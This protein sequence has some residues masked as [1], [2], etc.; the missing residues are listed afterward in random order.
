MN[1][2]SLSARDRAAVW[3]PFTPQ[4]PVQDAVAL[5][6]GEGALLFGEDGR[7]Y[8]DAT[9]SWWVNLHGHAHPYIAQKIAVQLVTLEHA[10]FSGF[11]HEPAVELA[12]RL[13]GRLPHMSKVFYSDDGS[14]A[15][16]VALKMALQY[17]HNKGTPRTKIVAFENAY[18]GDT[19]GAMSA[20]ARNVFSRAFGPLLFEVVH[21][22]VPLPGSEDASLNALTEA[23]DEHTAAFIAEPLIQGAGG[24]IMYEAE[25]LSRIYQRCK[26][27]GIPVIAD[28]VMTG[29]GRTGTWFA[30]DQCTVKP[31]MICLSKGL[32]GGFMPLGVTLCT[33]EI[34]AAFLTSDRTRTFFH[35]HSYTANATACAA[36]LASFDLM[37]EAHTQQQIHTLAHFQ[38]AQTRRLKNH[39]AVMQARCKGTIAA[40]ELRSTESTSYLNP[41]S[42]RVHPFFLERGVILRPLGNIIYVL[43]PYCITTKQ[44]E[45]VYAA[46]EEFLETC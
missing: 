26:D 23:L 31:D 43:P 5:V 11:T 27:K 42:E 9:A 33:E 13:L 18:H 22:P 25:A 40:F 37:E 38:Q 14:T 28:E 10:I 19:F 41:I 24:M 15:V 46:L 45:Q 8:I 7:S 4:L 12:E 2:P 17:W 39:R 36:A 35:G 20:G 32:T 34:H 1:T 16:E 30:S 3:H 29:F 6:R 44:L 21:I